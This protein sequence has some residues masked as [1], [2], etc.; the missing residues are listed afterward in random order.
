MIDETRPE[1]YFDLNNFKFRDVFEGGEHVWG[2]LKE[3]DKYIINKIKELGKG[4]RSGV[5][6]GAYVDDDVY[7]GKGTT[8]DHTV[9]IH[10]PTIIGDNCE[11]RAGA[12]FRGNV[13]VGDRAVLGGEYKSSILFNETNAPHNCYVGNSIIGYKANIAW[14]VATSTHTFSRDKVKIK[15]GDNGYETGMK[16]FGSIVGDGAVIGINSALMPGSLIGQDSIIYP[17]IIWR[18]FLPSQKIVKAQLD[19]KKYDIVNRNM[20]GVIRIG[21]KRESGKL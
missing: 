18:G 5:R 6:E 20:E 11:I 14:G 7:L 15:I 21:P 8:V 9:V 3:L 17:L 1:Y 10:G 12:R 4:D 16:K 2:A 13:L 19:N